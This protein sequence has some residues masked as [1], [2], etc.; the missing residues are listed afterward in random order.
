MLFLAAAMIW[1]STWLIIKFQLGF[2][3]P[4]VSVAYRFMLAGVILLVYGK[5]KRLNMRFRLK[6]HGMMLLL[7]FLLFGINYWLVYYAELSL[8]SGLVAIVFSS[9]IFLNII[10]GAWLLKSPMRGYVV[11]GAIIGMAG[12]V[13]VFKDEIIRFDLANASTIAFFLAFLGA[14]SAS[15]GNITSAYL[16][17]RSG[18]PVVQTNA[19]AMLYGSLCMLGL[20]VILGK[21]LDFEFSHGYIFS[22]V[23]LTIFGS[24]IAF[25]CYLTLLGRIGADKAAYI[26]L[27]IPVLALILSTIFE[28]YQWNLFAL[29]GVMLILAGNVIVLK[30]RNR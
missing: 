1:G 8:P 5:I 22:L 20:I 23:Y 9:I 26:T 21:P 24:I 6:D 13:L 15:L 4:M 2:V 19:F 30:K 16:Q 12:M 3:D 7:G 10:N 14:I 11:L 25:G 27:V 29:A 17:K 18:M 28:G